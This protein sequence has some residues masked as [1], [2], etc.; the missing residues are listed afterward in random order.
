MRTT[1]LLPQLHL[2]QGMQ[3][4]SV[5][6]DGDHLQR[7]AVV[8]IGKTIGKW[9]FKMFNQQIQEIWDLFWELFLIR[10]GYSLKIGFYSSY[11]NSGTKS[12]LSGARE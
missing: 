7:K 4:T 3:F 2:A 6:V 12:A 1:N 11:A 9:W 10:H 8:F 5:E